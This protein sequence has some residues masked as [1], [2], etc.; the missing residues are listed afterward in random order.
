MLWSAGILRG[1]SSSCPHRVARVYHSTP[2]PLTQPSNPDFPNLTHAVTM[3]ASLDQVQHMI[4]EP[5]AQLKQ[6]KRN[7]RQGEF[8]YFTGTLP[9]SV[10]WM[11][12]VCRTGIAVSIRDGKLALFVPFCNPDYHNSWSM[13][14]Q[15]MVPRT[16]LPAQH[17]WANGWLLCGDQVSDQLCSDTG[18]CAIL[19]MLL[20]CCDTTT[21]HDC[22]FIINR[23]DSACVRLDYCDPLNPIDAHQIPGNRP[24]L[25][26]VLSSYVGDQFADVAMPLATDWHRLSKGT[27]AAQRPVPPA[28]LPK[29]ISWEQK[30]DCVIFRGSL[31]GTGRHCGTHQRMALLRF[32][33]ERN[34]DFRATGRNQR[35]RYCPLEKCVTCPDAQDMDA[36]KHHLIDMHVQQ[37]QYQYTLVIDGHSGAD[38]LA[39]LCSG[40]QVVFKVDSPWHALCPDTWASQRLH[41]WEHYIPV[42]RNMD[43]LKTK[44]CWARSNNA[45]SSRL[46]HNCQQW[47]RVERRSIIQWW[48]DATKKMK[49]TPN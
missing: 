14:A 45:A 18:V 9:D 22:D 8:S 30:K 21:M 49:G 28:V 13:H 19:N 10:M 48:Q 39:R 47:S 44:L 37:E 26:P 29:E 41:E 5:H 20:V 36:G 12:Y 46:R 3:A 27:F 38:R 43:D 34:F 23:R 2:L 31:T 7:Q 33:D 42:H 17:W 35:L 1:H 16:G 40:D 25:V 32:H 11:W 4:I 6:L 24:P 15:S